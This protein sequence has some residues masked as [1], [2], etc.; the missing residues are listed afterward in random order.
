MQRIYRVRD[1]LSEQE[2][3]TV[4]RTISYTPVLGAIVS[5]P[6]GVRVAQDCDLDFMPLLNKSL[7]DAE[8]EAQRISQESNCPMVVIGTYLDPVVEVEYD[9]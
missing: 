4:R 3:S 9:V 6:K 5:T 1:S 8:I 7:E 2:L